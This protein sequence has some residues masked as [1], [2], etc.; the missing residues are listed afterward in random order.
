MSENNEII[1]PYILTVAE[2]TAK[3]SE[4]FRKDDLE[5]RLQSC[6]TND[7]GVWALALVYVTSRAIQDRLDEVLGI[8]NWRNEIV[9]L[10]GM[11]D[12][13]GGLINDGFLCGL[14][15]RLNGEWITKWDGAENT[16]IA[17]I[18]GGISNSEKRAAV[19]WGIGR[20]LYNL[21]ERFVE[22]TIDKSFRNKSRWK[23]GKTRDKVTFYWQMPELETWALHEDD[24]I[25][26]SLEYQ[27]NI[28]RALVSAAIKWKD[29]AKAFELQGL[30]MIK[31]SEYQECSQWILDNKTVEKIIDQETNEE[32]LLPFP[33]LVSNE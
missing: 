18:K 5:W 16:D 25:F 3:L 27:K 24:N 20:Y 7:N 8:E 1:V 28:K 23:Q 32:I 30:S 29:F 17:S 22:C 15:L 10:S 4:P 33:A 6:G 2:I 26:I 14:S 11:S 21:K 9:P 31:K 13:K 19:Q 12:G